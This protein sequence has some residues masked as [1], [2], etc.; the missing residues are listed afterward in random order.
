MDFENDLLLATNFSGSSGGL[1]RPS[2]R[3]KRLGRTP[4]DSS[5]PVSRCTE[6]RVGPSTDRFCINSAVLNAMDRT[7]NLMWERHIL[8]F[9]LTTDANWSRPIKDFRLVVDKEST[10]NLVSF[11]TQGVRKV[12]PTQIEIRIS[13]FMPTSNLSI[14]I[15][16]PTHSPANRGER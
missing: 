2:I 9:I 3:S 11:C 8:E 1:H 7:T 6:V 10:N 12:G 14:L 13:N 4:D 15:L 5:R 16:S